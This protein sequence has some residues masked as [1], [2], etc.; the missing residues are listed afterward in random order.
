MQ[1][2]KFAE[3]WATPPKF[4][5]PLVV[6]VLIIVICLGAGFAAFGKFQEAILVCAGGGLLL[7]AALLD[8]VAELIRY[9]RVIANILETK[10]QSS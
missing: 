10:N 5:G 6:A 8:L 7:F 9:Q 1:R 3:S 2:E 4:V